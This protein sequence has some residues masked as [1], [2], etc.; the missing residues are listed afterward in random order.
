MTRFSSLLSVSALL[1]CCAI[2][3]AGDAFFMGLGALDT[4]DAFF[5]QAY[6]ISADG[7]AIVGQTYTP[8]GYEPF[9]WTLETGLV[10]LGGAATGAYPSTSPI[11][12]DASLDGSVVVGVADLGSGTL[13]PFRWTAET[14][15]V[16]VGDLPG[17]TAVGCAYECSDD[18][19]VIVGSSAV[20]TGPHA[21]RWTAE[22]GML[23]LGTL[24]AYSVSWAYG[25][26]AD[27]NVVVGRDMS[28]DDAFRWTEQD[29]MVALPGY[30]GGGMNNGATATSA[31]GS[32]CVGYVDM[33]SSVITP[34]AAMWG[35]DGQLTLLPETAGG[36]EPFQ[37]T[38]VSADGQAIVGQLRG[39]G[40]YLWDPAHG[41]RDLQPL[42]QGAYGLDLTGWTLE[43]AYT[44]SGDGLTIAGW[45]TN[46]DGHTE[47]FVAHLPEPGTLGLLIF[48][49]PLAIRRRR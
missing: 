22:T 2:P 39:G 12:L 15:L 27:G 4:G 48:T 36:Q 43:N 33:R 37:A 7:T 49:L 6:G 41:T 29:G 40:V 38:G 10:G 21:F 8:A 16:S 17:G 19:Q 18:G 5:S 47:A 32:V 3:A 9:R 46:P 30:P 14:G 34:R 23:D 13:E 44:V 42:L 28:Q 35:P 11:A 24:D 45:G 26:S 25:V 1:V 31:D 20:A